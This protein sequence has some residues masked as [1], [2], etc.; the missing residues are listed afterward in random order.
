MVWYA[1]ARAIKPRVLVETGVSQGLGAVV[2]CA[3]LRP[4][5][6]R[7]PRGPLLRH[8]HQS[9]RGVFAARSIQEFG[10]VIIGDS[11]KSLEALDEKI[12][13]FIND[14]NHSADYEQA[15]YEMVKPKLAEGAILL[16]DNSHVTSRLAEFSMRNGRNFVFL[17]EEPADHWYRGAGVGVSFTS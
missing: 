5:Q 11:L 10:D 2:L 13:L 12:D 9:R 1:V 16:G 15:E 14:S 7:G 4:E 8:R 6:A 17:S 3:A